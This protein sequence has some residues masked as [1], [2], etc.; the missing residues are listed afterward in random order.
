MIA[1]S[2]RFRRAWAAFSK[3][4]AVVRRVLL[5]FCK[6][7]DAFLHHS[8][9]KHKT[10][11]SLVKFLLEAGFAVEDIDRLVYNMYDADR[12]YVFNEHQG[13]WDI[14]AYNTVFKGASSV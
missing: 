12:D 9:P 4:S 2:K 14:E 13:N 8:H 10:R 7:T 1:R 11:V 3:V 6:K 5:S